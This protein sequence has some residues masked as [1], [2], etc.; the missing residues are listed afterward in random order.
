M[1]PCKLYFTNSEKILPKNDKHSDHA[2]GTVQSRSLL[3]LFYLISEMDTE[4]PLVV[5]NG[6][7]VS[8]YLRI[9]R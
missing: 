6:T 3:Q 8:I 1:V 2:G 9:S 5:D 4:R 7:G